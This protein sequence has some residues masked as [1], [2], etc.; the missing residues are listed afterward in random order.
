MI[1]YLALAFTA[2][3]ALVAT[4]ASA[5]TFL[6]FF[7]PQN[8]VVHGGGYAGTGGE[9]SVSVCLDPGAM[10]P[11]GNPEQAIRNAV[12]AFNALV[13]TT[14]NVV[15]R[16]D[17]AGG[18]DF[19]SVLLHEVGHCV[20]M[21]HSALGPSEVGGFD[22]PNIYYANAFPGPNAAFDTNAGA[23]GVRG[24]RDDVRADDISRNWFRKNTN[25]PF[26]MPPATVDRGTY[27]MTL[28][29]LPVG[30]AFVEN[31]TSFAP[32][33]GPNTSVLRGATPTQ[34]T[35]FPVICSNNHVRRL[36]PDDVALL[37]IARA[38]LNGAQ[39]N[40]DDYSLKL[41]YIGQASNCNIKIQFTDDAGFARCQVTA[42]TIGG[43]TD[44][45][46]T[47]GTA[48]FLRTGNWY[49]NPNDTTGGGGGAPTC[50]GDC[51]FRN[52]FE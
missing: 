37:R 8:R 3:S 1:R 42:S 31:S 13:P 43:S 29:D 27:S 23:D 51:I 50:S 11:S 24:S 12:A 33:T 21:D 19:E 22:S 47:S 17:G 4:S 49:Y 16:G 41:T 40:S 2:A 48:Q 38:G 25:N 46:V 14:G 7:P 32:C 20:G 45:R 34:N 10:P 44:L 35:M 26:E 39:G 52:G 15:T 9:V 36:A 5:G 30:H 6:D 18:S 28:S